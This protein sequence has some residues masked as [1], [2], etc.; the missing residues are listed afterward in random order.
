M[1]KQTEAVPQKHLRG[2]GDKGRGAVMADYGEESV[3][4]THTATYKGRSEIRRFFTDL[5]ACVE[6]DSSAR[7][8]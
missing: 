7:S 3:L 4:I 1:T 5:R 8:R 2:R 6:R